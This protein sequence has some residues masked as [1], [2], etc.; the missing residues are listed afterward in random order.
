MTQCR[1]ARPWLAARSFPYTQPS[2]VRG[3]GVVQVGRLLP[4]VPLCPLPQHSEVL[5]RVLPDPTHVGCP[6]PGS[7]ASFPPTLQWMLLPHQPGAANGPSLPSWDLR[8][9]VMVVWLSAVES[10]ICMLTFCTWPFLMVP[11]EGKLAGNKS[12]SPPTPSESLRSAS[13]L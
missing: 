3:K 6:G 7:A 11:T 13:H 12:P 5:R 10:A 1:Q 2:T 4:T 9:L 8:E